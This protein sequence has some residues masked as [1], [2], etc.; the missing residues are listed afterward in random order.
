[1]EIDISG[2]EIVFSSTEI[3]FSPKEIASSPKEIN[4]SPKEISLHSW[5]I[6]FKITV[7]N[8]SYL[9]TNLKLKVMTPTWIIFKLSTNHGS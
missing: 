3:I 9:S 1:M 5:E 7:A 6:I 8:S 4:N 2:T